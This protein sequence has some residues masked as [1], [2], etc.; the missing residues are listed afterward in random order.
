MLKEKVA[1]TKSEIR[2]GSFMKKLSD[3]SGSL[4]Q[5]L[6][7]LVRYALTYLVGFLFLSCRLLC[8][9]MILFFFFIFLFLPVINFNMFCP[10]SLGSYLVIVS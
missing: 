5:S 2:I 3:G 9:H 10:H 8:D 7:Q 1:S 4:H 6:T